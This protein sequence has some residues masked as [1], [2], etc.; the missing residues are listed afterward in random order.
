VSAGYE[1]LVRYLQNG[2]EHGE[3]EQHRLMILTVASSEN[4]GVVISRV[5]LHSIK[6]TGIKVRILGVVHP[7]TL[8]VGFWCLGV[9]AQ[10]LV[11]IPP[12]R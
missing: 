1:A 12:Y 9:A 3:E 11:E 5:Y 8:V 7:S 6:V 10:P 2:Q 4:F